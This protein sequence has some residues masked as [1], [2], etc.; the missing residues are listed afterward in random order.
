MRRSPTSIGSRREGMLPKV[1]LMEFQT[2]QLLCRIL[3]IRILRVG[4]LA[5]QRFEPLTVVGIG[6]TCIPTSIGKRLRE[7]A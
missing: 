6:S 5:W 2:R 3:G 7:A 1:R 4:A